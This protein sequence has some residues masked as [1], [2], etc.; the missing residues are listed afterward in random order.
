MNLQFW[1]YRI[2]LDSQILKYAWLSECSRANNIFIKLCPQQKN[3]LVLVVSDG[4][5]FLETVPHL[6]QHASGQ[7]VKITE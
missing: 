1:E 5:I 6:G 2:L 7:S 4:F 3:A